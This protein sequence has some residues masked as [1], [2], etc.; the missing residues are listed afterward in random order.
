D[1]GWLTS[2]AFVILSLI[3]LWVILAR[4]SPVLYRVPIILSGLT[5]ATLVALT[6]FKYQSEFRY[7]RAVVT[8]SE[9][10]VT[11]RPSADSEIEFRAT[12]GLEIRITSS[13]GDYFLALFENKRQGWIPKSSADRL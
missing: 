8:E 4:P 10:P 6:A 12:S 1:W 7:D 9:T 2:A 3:I 5:L 13:S 11:S